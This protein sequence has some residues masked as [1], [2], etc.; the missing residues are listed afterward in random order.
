MIKSLR[1][2]LRSLPH[3]AHGPGPP[4]W[5]RGRL[6]GEHDAGQQ[7]AWALLRELRSPPHRRRGRTRVTFGCFRQADST[8]RTPPHRYAEKQP[9]RPATAARASDARLSLSAAAFALCFPGETAAQSF[10]PTK[11]QPTS[12]L[13]RRSDRK[14][15]DA[16]RPI[17]QSG[18][19]ASTARISDGPSSRSPPKWIPPARCANRSR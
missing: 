6:Q 16:A 3:F 8:A 19:A 7:T 1:L 10:T 2:S 12:R 14:A 9:A 4:L 11:E 15:P 5:A 13:R 17:R 18:D